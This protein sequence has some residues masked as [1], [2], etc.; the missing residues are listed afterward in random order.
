MNLSLPPDFYFTQG[1]IPL[2]VSMPHVGT[3]IPDTI[4]RCL[5]PVAFQKADTDWHLPNLYTFLEPLGASVISAHWSR[6][7]I[8]LNRPPENTN[9]YP[10][11]DTTGLCP[12]DTFHKE[13]LYIPGQEPAPEEIQ[14]R[15][16]D[17]WHPYHTQ[18]SAEIDRMIRTY[19][20]AIIWD[21]HSIASVVPRFF[22]GTLPD[23][24]LGTANGSSCAP[25]LNATIERILTTQ[26]QYSYAIN[27]RFKGGYITRHYGRPTEHIHTIQL[28]M[29]QCT[30]MEETA[31]FSYRPDLAQQIQPLIHQMLQAVLE[32]ATHNN[33]V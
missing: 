18:L 10:G 21:A 11:Q 23:L 4:A 6:Y 30:Y 3:E 9:L 25:S 1:R 7:V 20:V 28:E 27:Q 12:I 26:T 13:P 29:A 14:R 33:H 2:L 17:Y 15:L 22:S 32:W 19:G 31:P 24:N 5:N 8:D 16:R